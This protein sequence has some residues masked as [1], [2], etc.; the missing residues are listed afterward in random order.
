MLTFSHSNR[1]KLISELKDQ[2]FDLVVIG[3]GITGAGIALDAVTR[4]M[5]V[6]LV[7]KPQSSTCLNAHVRIKLGL[8]GWGG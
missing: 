5:S 1:S 2:Y 3:G 6:A 8:D 7:E 4:G